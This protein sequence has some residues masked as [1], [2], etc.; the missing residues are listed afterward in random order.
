MAA[1]VVTKGLSRL[2]CCPSSPIYDVKG[3]HYVRF[4]GL[5]HKMTK[6][7]RHELAEYRRKVTELRKQFKQEWTDKVHV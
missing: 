4:Y 5:Q 1:H 6:D 3:M 7:E 2:C